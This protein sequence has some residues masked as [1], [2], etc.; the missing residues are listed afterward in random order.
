M[1]PCRIGATQCLFAA[2]QLVILFQCACARK[3]NGASVETT[4]GTGL[5][6]SKA[7]LKPK[8]MMLE[9]KSGIDTTV[10]SSPL[11]EDRLVPIPEPEVN[12]GLSRKSER[13]RHRK[14]NRRQKMNRRRRRK[15]RKRKKIFRDRLQLKGQ[16]EQIVSRANGRRLKKEGWCKT[17]RMK[18]RVK[19]PGCVSRVV[20]NNFCRGQ[21]NSYYVPRVLGTGQDSNNGAFKSCSFCK[22]NNSAVTSVTLVCPGKKPAYVYKKMLRVFECLCLSEILQS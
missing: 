4:I 2:L 16:T 15:N 1:L 14:K 6:F 13:R 21:C 5:F 8:V 18:L 11:P 12:L 9:T 10:Y 17:E 19:E 7:G 20:V 22:P 3:R